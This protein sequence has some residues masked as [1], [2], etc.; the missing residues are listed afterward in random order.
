MRAPARDKVT[1]KEQTATSHASHASVCAYLYSV[2]LTASVRHTH[3][4]T[5][6]AETTM[7]AVSVLKDSELL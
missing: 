4:V 6:M 3:N 1:I 5:D 7:R 2:R